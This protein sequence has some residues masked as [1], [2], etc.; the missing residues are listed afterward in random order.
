M[1]HGPNHRSSAPLGA[2]AGAGA[3][4]HR[5]VFVTHPYL[6]ANALRFLAVPHFTFVLRCAPS[7][8]VTAPIGRERT[9][10]HAS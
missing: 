2:A 7:C 3:S 1:S 8:R 10:C 9:I 5:T 6:S 4:Q